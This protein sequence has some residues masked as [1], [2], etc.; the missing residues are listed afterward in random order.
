M[1][2]FGDAAGSGFYG[3]AVPKLLPGF[4]QGGSAQ[5]VGIGGGGI[6]DGRAPVAPPL[7]FVVTNK[8]N[9]ISMDFQR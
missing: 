4:S 8:T 9:I 3:L 5:M 7:R 6:G 1:A 2:T